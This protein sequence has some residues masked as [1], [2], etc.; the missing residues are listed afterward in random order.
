MSK[1]AISRVILVSVNE[2]SEEDEQQL[3]ESHDADSLDEVADTLTEQ[4]ESLL[5][6]RTFGGADKIPLLSVETD[7]E[8]SYNKEDYQDLREKAE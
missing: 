8:E 1:V 5:A 4:V 3:L 6:H 7:I 2:I